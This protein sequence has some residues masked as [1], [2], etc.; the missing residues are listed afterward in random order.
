MAYCIEEKR[1]RV[2]ILTCIEKDDINTTEDE[3][4]HPPT[5]RFALYPGDWVIDQSTYPCEVKDIGKDVVKVAVMIPSGSSYIWLK[6]E[7]SIFYTL[8]NVLRK[9]RPPILKSTRG[10]FLFEDKW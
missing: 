5:I 1:I 4:N 2:P 6:V 9:I 3:P 8:K 7:D 10:R